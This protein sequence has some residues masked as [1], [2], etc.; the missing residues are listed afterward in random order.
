MGLSSLTSRLIVGKYGNTGL[1]TLPHIYQL[2]T[3]ILAVDNLLL[4]ILTEYYLLI[5]YGIVYGVGEG[6]VLTSSMHIVLNA[7]P[8]KRRGSGF[9]V[10]TFFISSSYAVAPPFSGKKRITLSDFRL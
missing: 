2:G 3:Y 7:L 1:M 8:L 4:P 5:M 6:L 10:Y 9:G